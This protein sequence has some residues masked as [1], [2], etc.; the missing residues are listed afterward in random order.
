[1]RSL[2]RTT[3]AGAAA[4]TRAARESD[5]EDFEIAT[6][7]LDVANGKHWEALLDAVVDSNILTYQLT[8]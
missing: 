3:D 1:M 5:G 2:G 4:L 7:L 6:I 8:D